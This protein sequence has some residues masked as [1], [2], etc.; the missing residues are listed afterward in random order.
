MTK[1]EDVKRKIAALLSMTEDAGCSEAEALAAAGRAAALMAEYGLTRSDIEIT[2]ISVKNRTKGFGA[3]DDLWW[4]VAYC[5]N[6]SAMVLRGHIP[7]GSEI[8]FIGA[9]PGPQIAAY[10]FA[11]LTR[12]LDRHL[13]EFKA[14]KFYRRRRSDA[15]RRIAVRDFTLGLVARLQLRLIDLFRP[16]IS[17]TTLAMAKSERDRRYPHAEDFSAP[18]YEQRF[19]AAVSEG[20]RS[21][22]QVELSHGVGGAPTARQ[23]GA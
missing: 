7:R 21:G 23:I 5:T 12:A 4:T 6:T 19:E 2:Q 15:T 10:L 8:V 9:E 1:R 20:W 16:T 22:T 13:E 3:R 14:G 17:S 11:I 18:I